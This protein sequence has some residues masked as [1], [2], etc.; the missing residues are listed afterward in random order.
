MLQEITIDFSEKIA[1][2]QTKIARLKDMIHDVRDQKIVL[3]DIKNNHM[4]RDTKLEL[5]LGGVLKC[6]VKINVGTLI[7][8]LEQNIEDDTALINELAKE[9]GIEV[10]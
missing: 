10:E 1:K 4:P 2:A 3:D 7:P 8:L 9:L 6:S 5:N